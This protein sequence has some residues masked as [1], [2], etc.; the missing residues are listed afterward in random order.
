MKRHAPATARNSA[1][2]AEVLRRE[3]PRTG[4]VL[5]IA[6]GTGEHAVYMARVFPNLTWQPSDCEADAIESIAAWRAGA[7]VS[8]IAPPVSLDASDQIWPLDHADAIFCCNM[9]HISPW[10]ATVGLFAGAGRLLPSNAPLILYGPFIDP[11]TPTAP[12]NLTFDASLKTRNPEWGL[13]SIP[14]LDNLAK[15]NDLVKERRHV[16]PANNLIL[17][18]RKLPR[19]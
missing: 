6:S 5:E 18:Y 8:N 10:A 4:T 11:K 7:K 9:I 12:S 13:R 15:A 19:S 1:A 14:G 17:I 16:M 3:L 2:I